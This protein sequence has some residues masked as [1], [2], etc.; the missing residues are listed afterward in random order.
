MAAST[1]V[2]NGA[3]Q[4]LLSPGWLTADTTGQQR[5]GRIPV[6]QDD[7]AGLPN[8]QVPVQDG[9]IDLDVQGVDAGAAGEA[10]GP[11]TSF[12]WPATPSTGAGVVAVT[13]GMTGDGNDNDDPAGMP[14]WDG[15]Q[16][17]YGG[18]YANHEPQG[19]LD[20]VAQATDSWGF[21]QVRPG[22]NM[23]YERNET[24]LMGNTSRG[25]INVWR[26]IWNVTPPVKTANQFTAQPFHNMDGSE[27]S[28]PAYANLGLSNS[29]GAAY[30]VNGP[31][32][33]QVSEA[34][35]AQYIVA[36]PT[37]GWA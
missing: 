27:G 7:T 26:P 35:P 14:G 9:V 22:A 16:L 18:A 8:P 13:P 34:T 15:P 33:P 31:E 6:T 11:T 24:R 36:D 1:M 21:N 5:S 30:Y 28:L 10:W 17:K 3:V 19:G 20:A 29:G 32:A 12:P 2:P 37:A 4:P 23:G 25:Y